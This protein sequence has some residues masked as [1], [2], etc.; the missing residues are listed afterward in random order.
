[1]TSGV[2]NGTF[3]KTQTRGYNCTV[4]VYGF[5]R[6]TRAH[7]FPIFCKNEAGTRARQKEPKMN[8]RL[9]L[10]GVA[11]F[12]ISM[13]GGIVFHGLLLRPDYAPLVASGVMRTDADAAG[14]LPFMIIS[15][16]IKG[17][18]FAWIYTKG[19]TPGA[20]AL[21]QGLKFGL[22]TVFLVT[23]PLYLVYYAVEPMPGL[24]VAKQI[25]S[26]TIVM[27]LMGVAVSLII[28]S[29]AQS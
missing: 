21:M 10:A 29:P 12:L 23:I 9:I 28:K 16:L 20:P 19:L 4:R 2:K 15:H 1:L 13:I 6:K 26:D 7:A 5:V 18:A 17:I 3:E 14:Y 8:L 24:L 11:G 22:A 27:I 25:V